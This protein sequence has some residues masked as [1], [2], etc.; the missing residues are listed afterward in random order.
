MIL[1]IWLTI[2]KVGHVLGNETIGVIYPIPNWLV[3][4]FLNGK[5]KVF[6]KFLVHDTTN[7]TLKN[8][9]VFYASYGSKKLVGEGIIEGI[10]F[11]Y[12]EEILAK[13]KEELFISEHQFTKY[14]SGRRKKKLLVLVLKN[15][16]KY[17]DPIT[18]NRPI[19]MAGKYFTSADYEFF[20]K[21]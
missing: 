8:K 2:V 6:C 21:K 17:E 9:V 14:V 15:I 1:I 10:E 4:G 11:L 20:N 13:Y 5:K 19:T 16:V 18:Y 3:D 12:P 7:L